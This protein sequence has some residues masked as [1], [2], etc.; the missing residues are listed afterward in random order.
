MIGRSEY[1]RVSF[2]VAKNAAKHHLGHFT[3]ASSVN[4]L[5]TGLSVLVTLV[6]VT[7]GQI[8]P[9]S[10]GTSV[11][12]IQNPRSMLEALIEAVSR[13]R[14]AQID[15]ATLAG[16][17]GLRRQFLYDL[18]DGTFRRATI[19]GQSVFATKDERYQ[20]I[21]TACLAHGITGF[22]EAAEAAQ[23]TAIDAAS[24][25]RPFDHHALYGPREAFQRALDVSG[26]WEDPQVAELWIQLCARLSELRKERGG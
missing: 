10:G 19:D 6:A 24:K 7:D 15:W 16:E 20:K 1:F 9:S 11:S 3:T 14:G 13:E 17:L 25:T 4:K 26:A 8:R 21:N 12:E 23:R 18:R 2:S 22:I 5:L